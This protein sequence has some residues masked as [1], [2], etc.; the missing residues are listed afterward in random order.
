MW[1]RIES[2]YG[3][4]KKVTF[5]GHQFNYLLATRETQE[6]AGRRIVQPTTSVSRQWHWFHWR[7]TGLLRLT[8]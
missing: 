3:S 4:W 7:V 5:Y 2:K 1:P 6:V 8:R